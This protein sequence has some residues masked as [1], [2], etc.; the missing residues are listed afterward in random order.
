MSEEKEGSE[1]KVPLTTIKE[2]KEH[3]NATSLEIAVVYGFEVIVAKGQYKVGDTVIYIPPD[4]ILPQE[5]HDKI[6][7]PDSKIKLNKN[8]VKQ[9]KIRGKYS[10]GML[11]SLDTLDYDI[12]LKNTIMFAGLE[13]DASIVLGITKYEP[14]QAHYQTGTVKKRD[15]KNENPFFHK[16]GGI[17]N[18]KWYPDLF[19]EG[20]MVS[21]TEKIHGSNIRFGYVPYVANNL[22]RKLLKFLK[23]TPQWEW[24]Y[25]S[26]NVQY[27]QKF[28]KQTGYYGTDV[29]GAVLA[30]YNAKDKVEHGEIW[31]G[32]LYGDGIQGGYNYGC[33]NG[34]HKLLVFDLKYQNG[35]DAKFAD[36]QIF[37]SIAKERGFEVA[38]ELYRGPFNID[39]AKELTK[40]DSVLEPKQKI[41]EGVVIKPLIEQDSTIGRKLLKLISEKYLEKDQTEFH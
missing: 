17:D 11:L 22:W 7:G 25:G 9:I 34:E 32:E 30:K 4:S 10:Q 35:T 14:P 21:I 2:I 41:R 3:D 6:F 37:E 27:Q 40:G 13:C 20:E 19:V 33:K 5:L 31:Y 24:V 23:L 1:Y 12:A 38:P 8:R 29:Y 28:N 36:A 26:N 39:Q 16:Y 18:F 15:K